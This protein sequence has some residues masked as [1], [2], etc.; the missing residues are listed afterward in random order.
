V[1]ATH[2][3]L[4]KMV[5]AGEFRE[6]LFYRVNVMNISAP[7]LR[8]R[9]EDIPALARHFVSK[10]SELY[11]KQV[12]SVDPGAVALLKRYSWPGNIRELENVVQRSLIV[13]EGDSI[14][15]ED[16][17]DAIQDLQPADLEGETSPDGSFE[18]LMRIYK[19]RLAVDAVQQCNGN[20]TLA[21]QSLSISRAYLHRLI[22][23]D[24]SMPE[25]NVSE[26]RDARLRLAA[27]G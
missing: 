15:V 4:G 6:D 10:Y 27:A 1:L 8:Q 21:A 12:D 9:P 17:P 18:R 25:S 5:A 20:K 11:G 3:D 13:A 16:L 24:P 26:F 22:R 14:R 2:R 7:A 23:L 19:V